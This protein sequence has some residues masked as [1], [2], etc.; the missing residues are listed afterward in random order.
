MNLKWP[1]AAQ[2]VYSTVAVDANGNLP[3]PL[4]ARGEDRIGRTYRYCLV[5][6]SD[7]VVG[8]AIQAPAQIANQQDMTPSAAAIDALT[9]SVTPGA[10]DRA[11]NL[12]KDGLA[13]IDTTPG[14]GYSYPIKSH[15]AIT[16]S[17]AFTLNLERDTPIV[18]ALTGTSRVSLYSNP[19]RGVIQSPITTQTNIPVGVCQ[20]ILTTLQGG[21]LG[22]GGPFGTLIQGTPAIALG[23]GIPASAAGAVAIH[24]VATISLVGNMMDTGQD[25][26]VQAVRWILH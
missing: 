14:I 6:G 20:F 12:Y 16:G 21:W 1:A 10:T 11:A 18:V 7:L 23:V 4:G 5:G 3:H 2:P 13:V 9:I 25:G 24:A 8:D 19:Y 22:T 17:T 15:L 26:K